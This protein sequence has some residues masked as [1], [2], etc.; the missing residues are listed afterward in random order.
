MTHRGQR[1]LKWTGINP[2]AD[3]MEHLF[4]GDCVEW[5]PVWVEE[6]A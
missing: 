1:H 6:G 3:T 5:R 2:V 4:F